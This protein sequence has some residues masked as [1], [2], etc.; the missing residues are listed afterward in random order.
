MIVLVNNQTMIDLLNNVRAWTSM[1]FTSE[2]D[3]TKSW[4]G[5]R[6]LKWEKRIQAGD[7]IPVTKLR[8]TD[9]KKLWK[10]MMKVAD[11]RRLESSMWVALE[12][13]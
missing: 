10:G 11:V 6:S 5:E 12:P 13:V 1:E 4:A 7:I 9:G 2:F 3:P 8:P